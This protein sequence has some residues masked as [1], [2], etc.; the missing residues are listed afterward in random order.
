MTMFVEAPGP[1][2]AGDSLTVDEILGALDCVLSGGSVSDCLSRQQ[3]A[4]DTRTASTIAR[5]QNG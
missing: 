2:F 4:G 5:T 3:R 1:Y